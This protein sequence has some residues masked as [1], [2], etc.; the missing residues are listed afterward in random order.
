LLAG[1]PAERALDCI[2]ALRRRGYA[3]AAI[4]GSV[5]PASNRQEP[6]RIFL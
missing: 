5:L 6:I 3:H 2:A 4:I 1:V